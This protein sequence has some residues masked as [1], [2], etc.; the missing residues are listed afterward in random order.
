MTPQSEIPRQLAR[1]CRRLLAAADRDP[2]S[3]T[4]GCFD[5]RYWA[6][7]IV[8]APELTYQRNVYTLAWHLTQGVADVPRDVLAAAAAAGLVFAA[9]RQHADGSFDQAFPGEHS[10]G[11]TAFLLHDIAGAV[12]LLRHAGADVPS[13]AEPMMARAARFLITS[14]E[15]HAVIANHLAGA[16]A[17]LGACGVLLGDAGAQ[18]HA[19]T[20]L[21]HVLASQHDEGWFPEYGGADPGYQSLCLYYLA[22]ARESARDG[23][24]SRAALDDAMRRGVAFLEWFAHPD[25]SFGGEYGSRRTGVLYPGGLALIARD[26]AGAAPLARFALE[27]IAR[28]LLPGLDY[29]DDGNV[30]PMA[31]NCIATTGTGWPEAGSLPFERTQAS[32]DFPAAGLFVRSAGRLHVVIG[33]SNGGVI[34]AFDTRARAAVLEDTGY[35][36]CAAGTMLSS[37]SREGTA[38]TATFDAITIDASFAELSSLAPG[39]WRFVALRLVGLVAFRFLTLREWTKRYLVRRLMVPRSV[40][41]PRLRRAIR[42]EA[43]RIVVEDVVRGAGGIEWIEWGRSFVSVHMASARYFPG[44][45]SATAAMRERPAGR[46]EWQ[47]RFTIE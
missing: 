12:Q 29:L 35:A 3:P 2:Y 7:K 33:A 18:R 39:P 42:V 1:T 17:A 47:R 36:A 5:R 8:D 15:Q 40:A 14:R 24:A 19:G 6:W 31:M 10:Y 34:K 44:F 41:A 21:E 32:R 22:S 43:D 27:G 9:S 28:G 23:A 16:A 46:A 4:F 13:V 37:Q 45:G 38:W 30:A 25:G 11:A 26:H 20:L